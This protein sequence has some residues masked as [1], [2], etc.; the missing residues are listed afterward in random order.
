MASQVSNFTLL[1][2]EMM[3]RLQSGGDA[4]APVCEVVKFNYCPDCNIVM[5]SMN[6]NY[7]CLQ[8]GLQCHIDG[9]VK[10]CIEDNVTNLKMAS[11]RKVYNIASDYS[12]AQKK[13]I[14]DQ[15]IN[16]NS[17]YAGP[18][19]PRDVLVMAA[20][21]YNELQKLNFDKLDDDGNVCGESK[22]V[23]RGNIKNEILGAL[24]YYECIRAGIARR[25]KDIA[26]FMQLQNNGISRGEDILRKLHN[27]KKIKLPIN[28][29]TK[30]AFIARY[31]EA[32]G[33]DDKPHYRDFIA[34]LINVSVEKK[35]GM[36]S[37][38]SS[39]VVGT[40]WILIERERLTIDAQTIQDKCDGI[41]KNTWLRY[42]KVI[43]ENL[44]K[45]IGV[46]DKHNIDHGLRGRVMKREVLPAL[47]VTVPAAAAPV[48]NTVLAPAPAIVA[49]PVA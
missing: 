32:L 23:K 42:T 39:K 20:N 29:E 49:D 22:F 21:D 2:E 16:N 40:I 35:V 43:K 38:M 8:C 6:S 13:S 18:K 25:K 1:S 26:M 14:L 45:F 19:I 17:A 34:D 7:E 24:V 4:D 46:F 9:E 30:D 15:L 37:V 3:E 33:I 27:E 11:G 5:T 10:D 48:I 28:M 44:L 31:L 41:K 36:N 47:A 12:R